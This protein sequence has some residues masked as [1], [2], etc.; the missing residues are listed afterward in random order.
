MRAMKIDI[1]VS[2]SDNWGLGVA[3]VFNEGGVLSLGKL[4]IEVT[5]RRT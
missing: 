3:V 1:E 4:F 2:K 5:W